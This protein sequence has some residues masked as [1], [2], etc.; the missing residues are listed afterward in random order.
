MRIIAGRAHPGASE[1][2]TV[3][4]EAMVS[5][6]DGAVDEAIVS[7]ELSVIV[8]ADEDATVPDEIDVAI[9]REEEVHAIVLRV[10]VRLITCDRYRWPI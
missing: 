2:T 1:L 9:V 4:G 8:A 7:G 6:A 10:G 5:A 3:S